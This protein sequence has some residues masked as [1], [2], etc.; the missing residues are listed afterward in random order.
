[1]KIAIVTTWFERGAAYVSKQ[2]ADV[3][4]QCGHEV[5]IYARGGEHVEA[6]SEPWSSYRVAQD[7]TPRLPMPTG[8]NRKCFERFIQAN[9]IEVV[10][11]NE[12]RYWAP[13]LWARSLG[14]KTIAY[15]D[16]Y[17]EKT[18]PL[19]SAFDVL[20]CT[21]RRHY[22][23][24]SWHEGAEFVP[25]GTN[26]DL[27]VPSTDDR[28]RPL[29]K[30]FH[31]AGMNP[32]RK[33]TDL[34]LQAA[35]LLHEA[36]R[37]FSLFIHSQKPIEAQFPERKRDID[38][39]KH[40]GVLEIFHGTIGAP[41]L[42]STCDVYVYPSRLDGIGLTIAEALSCGLP[43][44]TT[45]NPPMNEFIREGAGRL[46][47]VE[48]FENRDDN[49]YWPMSIASISSLA[50]AMNYYIDNPFELA[51]AAKFARIHATENLNWQKN[52]LGVVA[53]CENSQILKLK[54]DRKIALVAADKEIIPFYEQLKPL[55]D[56][57]F[58]V[59]FAIQKRIKR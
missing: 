51:S 56:L 28:T 54:D 5:F 3:L 33:G 32:H 55:Y 16:Y 47:D 11:F 40:A 20:L 18:V 19:F 38:E 25:W 42:Y 26:I 14:L 1:M 27:F 8:M 24:F 7:P 30:F 15:V 10:L 13:V 44:V 43:V 41:G 35:V 58:S 29:V 57:A 59:I 2:M 34:L 4:E 36:N 45:N 48:R 46:V 23:A 50:E 31:S 37:P 6:V 52:G 9:Q 12:Q 53:A 22:E 49:Y 39:L 17:T 21:T